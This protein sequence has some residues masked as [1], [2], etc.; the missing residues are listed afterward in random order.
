[1]RTEIG[2]ILALPDTQEYL[3]KQAMEVFLSTPDQLANLIKTEIAKYATI[4]QTANIK[5]EE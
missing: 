3:A 4:V 2:A 5:M 1:M